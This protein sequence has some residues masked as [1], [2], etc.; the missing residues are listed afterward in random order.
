MLD[1]NKKAF[2]NLKSCTHYKGH[3]NILPTTDL[4]RLI[5]ISISTGYSRRHNEGEEVCIDIAM[6]TTK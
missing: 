2:V 6:V 4:L 5:E 3:T 1:H